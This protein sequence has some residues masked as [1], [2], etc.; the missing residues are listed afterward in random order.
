MAVNTR[1]PRSV[2]S[3]KTHSGRVSG[4]HEAH[5]DYF[6]VGALELERSRRVKERDA[7]NN[8]IATINARIAEID[9]EKAKLLASAAAVHD[10][11]A[12]SAQQE[13]SGLRIK[14]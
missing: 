11:I 8:R 4:T 10:G 5:R 13:P 2:S 3:I 6:Q 12:D 14:Y 1:P 7:A 9:S